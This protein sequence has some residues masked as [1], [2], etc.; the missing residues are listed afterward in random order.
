MG[1]FDDVY[2]QREG[3]QSDAPAPPP[4]PGFQLNQGASTPGAQQAP[5]GGVPVASQQGNAGAGPGGVPQFNWNPP[6]FGG[7]ATPNFKFDPVPQFTPLQ[8]NAPDWKNLAND[9]SYQFRLHQGLEALN[10]SAA[11][12][13]ASRTGGT[14]KDFINYGE[15]AASQE[16]DNIFRRAVDTYNLQEGAQRDQYA[17]Q[18]AAW[19]AKAG[20]ATQGGLAAFNQAYNLY[21]FPI[22]EERLREQMIMD[23]WARAASGLNQ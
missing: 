21:T 5:P 3:D 18:L 16:E 17:P 23:A 9:P 22:T 6:P 4:G 20:A 10:A 12:K 19:Q 11:A 1:L 8:F 2:T 14:L 7:S 15:N 13:G